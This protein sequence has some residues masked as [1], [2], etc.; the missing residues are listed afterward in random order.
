MGNL[1]DP[2]SVRKYTGLDPEDV[3]DENLK[4]YIEQANTVV[5]E[6]VAVQVIDERL[7]GD[8]NGSN[9]IFT[10]NYKHIADRDFD[11]V[12]SSIDVTVYKWGTAG[13]LSTR[14]ECTISSINAEEG[15]IYF[16]T[17]PASTYDVITINYYYY[18]NRPVWHTLRRAANL[19]AAY[20]YILAEYLLIPTSLRRGALSWRHVKPYKDLYERYL[21]AINRFNK[22]L[23]T[24]KKHSYPT[25]GE[26]Y[27]GEY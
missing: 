12:N 14:S 7:S 9:T 8:I 20:E 2:R 15:K 10:T 1:A 19:W 18:K 17:A 5:F 6:D 27:L 21:D 3:T 11:C 23:T 24:K 25:M 16:K 26:K 22:H 4:F 13:S